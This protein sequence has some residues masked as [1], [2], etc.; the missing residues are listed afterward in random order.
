[1]PKPV[2]RVIALDTET[3][4]LDSYH[5]CRPFIVTTCDDEGN[6]TLW[7]WDVDPYT[8]KVNIVKEELK[9]VQE[10]I[11][12]ADHLVLQ[13]AQFDYR[14]LCAAFNQLGLTL[15]W[16]WSKVHDL[17]ISSHLLAS[18]QL[19]D[20]TT[21][22]QVYL[23]INIK[24]YEEAM[25]KAILEARRLVRKKQFKAEYGE[26]SIA[27]ENM[28]GAP[29]NTKDSAKS[30]LWLPKAIASR[31]SYPED[32]PWHTVTST[33]ANVDS[34]VTVEVW[35]VHQRAIG[36]RKLF[37]IYQSRRKLVGIAARMQDTGITVHEPMIEELLTEYS[38][39]A[40]NCRN[41][42][43][44]IAKNIGYDLVLPKTSVNN[45]LREFVW[46]SNGLNLPIVKHAKKGKGGP[47]MD[48]GAIEQYLLMYPSTH[49]AHRFF[50][51]L[52]D[53]RK[54]E[55]AISYME[56]YRKYY[57][58]TG[59]EGWY[60]L[61]PTLNPAKNKTLRW[62]S[63]NPNEQNISKKEGFNLRR[64]FGPP[65]GWE[66]WSCDAKNIELRIPAYEAGEQAMI[67]LFERPDD[68][69]YYGSNHLLIFHILHE[70][71]WEEAVKEVGFEN[72]GP[73]C[74]KKYASTWY[75]YTK[76]GNF[77]VQYGAVELA[78]RPGTADLAYHVPGA[79]RK[80][81]ERFTKQAEL[82][83]QCIDFAN[84][85]GFVETIPDKHVDPYHGYPLECERSF[86]GK[87]KET[88][89]LNYHVQG[90]AMWWMCMAM[91]R[92][93]EFLDTLN[94]KRHPSKHCHLIM[95]VHDELVFAFPRGE[96]PKTNWPIIKEIMRLME[97]GGEGIGIPT[98]V[99]CEYHVENWSVGESVSFD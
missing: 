24:P 18:G 7:E 42:C 86:K 78:D 1:M 77:A 65:P 37:P 90:T 52:S 38:E 56:G 68:P 64:C 35:K 6:Q 13:N 41:V 47:S 2:S 66:W 34:A 84:A 95:Q 57:F 48:K 22:A 62:S 32:H 26:W 96:S 55:V 49:P 4:G 71:L 53:L 92:C 45:S 74:K 73:H 93:Q 23:G 83:R 43:T 91:I 99:S 5:D 61:H 10:V 58:P 63:S 97:L 11:A 12:S 29:S 80:I 70:K 81:M 33:Y 98:P 17:M 94:K 27:S 20:L 89:P 82:N 46:G 88:I 44:N 72:A 60:V 15:R 75:Q 76:N 36:E 14:M 87:V 59:I 69:P 28:P 79:Q 16:D 30:D 21:V 54:R 67:E 39:E 19:K 8:R 3:T 50:Q 85:H 25:D 51:R 9:E 31:C 40:L